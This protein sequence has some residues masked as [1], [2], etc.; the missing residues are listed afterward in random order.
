MFFFHRTSLPNQD[1]VSLRISDHLESGYVSA[2][3]ETEQ[4]LSIKKNQ[5]NRSI[6]TR[7][8][9]L[10]KRRHAKQ[11]QKKQE[12]PDCIDEDADHVDTHEIN[13]KKPTL[14]QRFD[15]LRRS[16]QFRNRNSTGKGKRYLLSN[17]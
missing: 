8:S 13:T 10:L 4:D 1:C 6:R 5:F 17:E 9:L 14:G 12:I 16:F 7:L 15:T 2:S 3:N 11:Q